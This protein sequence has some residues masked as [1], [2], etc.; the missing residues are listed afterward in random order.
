MWEELGQRMQH[1]PNII[2]GKIDFTAN[3]VDLV[4]ATITSFPTVL[5]F[6]Q[7]SK[8][9]PVVYAGKR[10]LASF[11]AFVET[12][13]AHTQAIRL[14]VTQHIEGHNEL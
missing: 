8:D 7:G 10:D 5:L 12:N 2:I 4:G 1:N 14:P 13:Q 3:D 6:K 9:T 11:V